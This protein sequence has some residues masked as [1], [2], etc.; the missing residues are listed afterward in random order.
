M[1]AKNEITQ[2]RM[3]KQFFDHIIDRTYVALV[4]GDFED[5]QGT[6]TGNIGRHPKNRKLMTVFPN[7]EKAKML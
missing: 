6:I 2:A 3:A 7:G 1:I 5:D 4:W